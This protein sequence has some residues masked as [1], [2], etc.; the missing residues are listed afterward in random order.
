MPK[1][2]AGLLPSYD[3]HE[4]TLAYNGNEISPLDTFRRAPSYHLLQVRTWTS[5]QIFEETISTFCQ[6]SYFWQKQQAFIFMLSYS[7]L[8]TRTFDLWADFSCPGSLSEAV[9]RQ[10]LASL[11]L[12]RCC[13]GCHSSN[14][15]PCCNQQPDTSC[16]GCRQAALTRQ[17]KRSLLTVACKLI[18]EQF[19]S[20]GDGFKMD[21]R[22]EEMG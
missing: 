9:Y 22:K 3:R 12:V 19:L 11:L 15:K 21:M 6:R 5:W 20:R 16:E 14:L 4:K 10:A 17:N 8:S 18:P 2:E 1:S 13:G 7:L